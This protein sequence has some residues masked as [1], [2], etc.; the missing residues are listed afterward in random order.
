MG[1]YFILV[2][3][4]VGT[5]FLLMAV[6][7]V[8]ARLGHFG[9]VTQAQ[10]TTLLMYVVTPCLI[11]DTLQLSPSPQLIRLMGQCLV[12]SVVTLL[13]F[14]LLMNPFFRRQEP[15]ARTVLRFGAAYGNVGYMGLPLV[16]GV[17]G[18]EGL[19]FAIVS[20][21]AFNLL[22]WSHGVLAMGERRG[23]SVRKMVV[24]PG[25]ISSA[26]G[27][28]LFL[29]DLRLPTVV[30]SAVSFL[31]SMNTPLAMI[32]IGAQMAFADLPATFRDRNLYQ[33]GL[34]KLVVF[35]LLTAAV[36]LP[37]GLDPVMY[38]TMVILAGTPSAGITSMFAQQFGRDTE[39]A[40]QLV[41]LT[42]LCCLVTLPCCAALSV[43]IIG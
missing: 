23:F 30:G 38:I 32:I 29:L 34:L 22:V 31:G 2:A 28:V 4:Q 7:Y 26:V 24:N 9:H 15:D 20:Q 17:L 5:L 36:L 6:G 18:S 25:I 16:Q 27:I 21:V 8:L 11:V 1:E 37:L 13:G 39:V 3:A 40:A 12:L 14:A 43:L 19:I 42:T 41:T 35:P 33:A 10:A